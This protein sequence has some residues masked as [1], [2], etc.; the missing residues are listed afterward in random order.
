MKVDAL[1]VEENGHPA[2]ACS[3]CGQVFPELPFGQV[4]A[5]AEFIDHADKVHHSTG[6]TIGVRASDKWRLCA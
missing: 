2:L 5:T 3:E 6:G 4:T 1:L